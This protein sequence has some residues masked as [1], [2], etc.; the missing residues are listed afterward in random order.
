[1]KLIKIFIKNFFHI[2]LPLFL[3]IPVKTFAFAN[4][5]IHRV[6]IAGYD[7]VGGEDKKIQNIVQESLASALRENQEIVWI[8][9][10]KSEKELQSSG[11]FKLM[12][13]EKLDALITG[14]IVQLGK[15]V[16]VNT[17][18]FFK[19]YER[20]DTHSLLS[21]HDHLL[22]DLNFSAKKLLENFNRPST[23][24]SLN[25][26]PTDLPPPPPQA[27]SEKDSQKISKTKS[28]QEVSGSGTT[29]SSSEN[30]VLSKDY[31]W[32]SDRLRFEARGFAFADFDGSHQNK[33]AIIDLNHV[34]LYGI[35][36][37]R[38][39]LLATYEAKENDHFVR[40]FAYDL[41]GDGI[42]EIL[43]SNIRGTQASSLALK[44]NS[45]GFTP[46]FRDAPWMIK[47]LGSGSQA[48]LLGEAYTGQQI[49]KHKIRQ[50]RWKDGKLQEIGDFKTPSEVEIY[51]LNLW[52]GSSSEDSRLISMSLSG[53]LRIYEKHKDGNYQR[54]LA[55]SESFGGTYNYIDVEVRDLF[56]QVSR[57]KTYI[58][59]DP[60]AWKTAQGQDRLLAPKN[61]T[62]LKNIVGTRPFPKNSGL[63]LL[64][65]TDMGIREIATTRKIEGYIS[66]V[67]RV[68]WPASSTRKILVLAGLREKG[69][70]NTMG[71]FQ[72]ALILY[73]FE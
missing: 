57:E 31:I 50:L 65:T 23:S 68:D 8:S 67:A 3:L 69:F 18:V 11:I 45:S 55:S 1:M 13:S 29:P 72:S 14:S 61:D 42:A 66:E 54:A 30:S 60:L 59:L 63:T 33:I 47:V 32:M 22:I 70:M 46:V 24:A 35:L 37:N 39:Q 49:D 52:E 73:D 71:R 53:D 21:D 2:F 10:R 62:F 16:Q 43:I 58:N 5:P 56:N 51:G 17:R 25:A 19:G 44:V 48:Q 27:L 36:Q 9:I 26:K 6:G 20:P 7:L 40:V 64:E 34:Y 28:P 4:G 41:D 12:T 38:L 15:S